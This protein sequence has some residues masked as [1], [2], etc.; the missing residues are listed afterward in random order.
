M[1]RRSVVGGSGLQRADKWAAEERAGE[2]QT[3]ASAG[4]ALQYAVTGRWCAY[5][6]T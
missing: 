3:I 5:L 4:Y 6:G 2:I 1:V